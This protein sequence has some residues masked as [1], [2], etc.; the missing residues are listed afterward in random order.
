[1]ATSLSSREKWVLIRVSTEDQDHRSQRDNLARQLASRGI[2][3]PPSNWLEMS[4]SREYVYTE[5]EF[6]ELRGRI[7]SGLVETIY[8]ESHSRLGIILKSQFFLLQELCVAKQTQIIDLQTNVNIVADGCA[9]SILGLLGTDEN[10]RYMKNVSYQ[11]TRGRVGK[12]LASNSWPSGPAPFGYGKAVY[13]AAGVKVW[14]WHPA[15]RK[16]GNVWR[17]NE[18][19]EMCLSPNEQGVTVP[20]RPKPNTFTIKLVPNRNQ[21]FV[22]TVRQIFDLYVRLGLS[23]HKIAHQ[24]NRE[25][26][27]FYDK[28]FTFE[29]VRRILENTAYVG[30]IHLG[31]TQTGRCNTI[32]PSGELK[33]LERPATPNDKR[34]PAVPRP[35]EERIVREN[36]HE[37]IVDRTTFEGAQQKMLQ[38][39]QLQTKVF[40]TRNPRYFLKRLLHCGH[41][42]KPMVGRTERYSDRVFYVCSSYQTGKSTGLDAKCGFH[43]IYHDQ[44][45]AMLAEQLRAMNRSVSELT[46]TVDLESYLERLDKLEAGDGTEIEAWF[47]LV[48][49]GVSAFCNLFELPERPARRKHKGTVLTPAWYWVKGFHDALRSYY[50]PVQRGKSWDELGRTHDDTKPVWKIASKKFPDLLK[51]KG[52]KDFA[53][54]V[55]VAEQEAVDTAR[56]RLEVI[57]R[58]YAQLN[59]NWFKANEKQQEDIKPEMDDLEREMEELEPQTTPVSERLNS[60][61]ESEKSKIDERRRLE[62][63]L[64]GMEYRAKGEAYKQIF[65]AVRLYWDR[66]WLPPIAKPTRPRKTDHKGQNR[67]RLLVDRTE[68]DLQATDLGFSWA[69]TP[70]RNSQSSPPKT[71]RK[72]GVASRGNPP[73]AGEPRN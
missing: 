7:E 8:V 55:F 16:L 35:V 20:P 6:Q 9:S 13:D 40:S 33:K 65:K 44:A 52:I 57:K 60:I 11:S 14:E 51:A 2:E 50:D 3:V 4:G 62:A 25:G 72:P 47:E 32:T 54:L 53:S 68:Y 59:R 28:L 58:D 15:L 73:R 24:L 21:S 71:P 10:D 17:P 46:N 64:P 19:G 42:G 56:A 29:T 36:A 69:G 43:T 48:A 67:Y 41:C 5:P 61:W 37:P 45:E 27:R 66:T 22:D 49:Q 31:K 39:R 23:F 63:E 30:D 12:L 18:H 38:S 34:P 1:M 26:A 70:R